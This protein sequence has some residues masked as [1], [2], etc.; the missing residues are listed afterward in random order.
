MSKHLN[1][2]ITLVAII[3]TAFIT[4]NF[5]N[6]GDNSDEYYQRAFQNNVKIFSPAIPDSMDFCGE[7]VPLEIY[8]VFERMD[9][10][11]LVNV[12]WQSNILLLIKRANRF[13]PIIEPILAEQGLPD[14]FK[15]LALA[16][17]GFTL[18]VSPAGA[19]G[20]WQF[21]KGTGQQYG[22]EINNEIDERY[23]LEKATVAAAKYLKANYNRF[24]NSWTLAAAA[25]NTGEGNIRRHIE[26]QQTTDYYNMHLPEET[27]RYLF[28]ILA[29]KTIFED[30]IAYG[31]ILREK[32]LYPP[33]PTRTVVVDTTITDLFAFARQQGT[34][35][36]QLKSLNPWLRSNHLPNKSRRTYKIFIPLNTSLLREKM[37]PFRDDENILQEFEN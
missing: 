36:Q 3:L 2:L 21:L 19:A 28:R 32:D 14:D 8:H 26:N 33:I 25:Y 5:Q 9:R 18:A 29:F 16:E 24:G 11:M 6:K 17:S 35:Y 30:P 37:F 7:R 10:E 13:F 23:H 15:Y 31:I 27:S 20:F 12:Y 22:L 1:L 34:T 4:L